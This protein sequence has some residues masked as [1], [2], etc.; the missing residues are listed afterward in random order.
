LP[1]FRKSPNSQKKIR[2]PRV[3]STASYIES[4]ELDPLSSNAEVSSG[5]ERI[6]MKADD[7]LRDDAQSGRSGHYTMKIHLDMTDI[8]SRIS[9]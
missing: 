4:A 3:F 2:V 6:G 8:H 5:A 9:V 1:N 7:E